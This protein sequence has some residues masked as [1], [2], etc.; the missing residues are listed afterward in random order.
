V[1]L[2]ARPSWG[3]VAVLLLLTSAASS[4]ATLLWEWQSEFVNPKLPPII[5]GLSGD[6]DE[7]TAQLTGRLQKSF[8]PG[9][10]E[11]ALIESLAGHGFEPAW[12]SDGEERQATL[13][14][15]RF[16]CDYAA[17]VYWR[18]DADRRVQAVRG[19]YLPPAC[20]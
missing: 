6:W 16:P 4:C 13:H 2:R 9:T 8:P 11:R 12:S 5:S 17:A 18:A 20:P 3:L 10:P 15:S 14:W 7:R 1:S 19:D